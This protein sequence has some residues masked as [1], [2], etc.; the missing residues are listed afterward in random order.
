MSEYLSRPCENSRHL[1]APIHLRASAA[2][3]AAITHGPSSHAWVYAVA[4]GL[5]PFHHGTAPP[6][7]QSTKI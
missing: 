5:F 2:R 7:P 4:G 3:G 6:W 1:W